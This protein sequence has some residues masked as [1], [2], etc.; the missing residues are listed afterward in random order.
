MLFTLV[1]VVC[2][3][4]AVF[5]GGFPL[6]DDMD[7]LS[8]DGILTRMAEA[9]R[10][11]H[12]VGE[13]RTSRVSYRGRL[14]ETREEIISVGSTRY[15]RSERN[16]VTLERLAYQGREY[17]RT[18]SSEEWKPAEESEGPVLVI[19]DE[20]FSITY[21][22]VAQV[23]PPRRIYFVDPYD[24]DFGWISELTSIDEDEVEGRA[25]FRIKARVQA[26]LES[27]DETTESNPPTLPS[28]VPRRVTRPATVKGTAELVVLR[29]NFHLLRLA[30]TLSYLS[31]TDA[32]TEVDSVSIFETMNES[33]TVPAP[34]PGDPE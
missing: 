34:M 16:N 13:E 7:R 29:Q 8:S 18:S 24:F 10:D 11:L 12:R 31:G 22:A 25:V 14:F 23:V 28:D 9:A 17:Y 6:E 15:V 20:G 1:W 2:A 21:D 19:D 3:L 27:D 32:V 26:P 33:L 30:T 5:E 4:T